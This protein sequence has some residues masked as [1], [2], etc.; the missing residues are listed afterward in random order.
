MN[1]ATASMADL[2]GVL[3]GFLLTLLVF[4][5]LFGDNVLFRLGI[6][7]FI[8]VSTGYIAVLVWNNI[9]WARL[10][11]PFINGSPGERLMA[12]IP[13]GLGVL[14][15]MKASPRLSGWGNLPVAFL[16]GV[17]A[18]AAVGGAILGTIFLR[19]SPPSINSI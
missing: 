12:L 15:L 6:H 2:F 4:S 18:A 19:A 1:I 16:V 11:V 5:Y 13:L 3:V 17:G 10:F 9:L 8:G 7:L 14:L